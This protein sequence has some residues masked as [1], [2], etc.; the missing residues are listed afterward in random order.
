MNRWLVLAAFAIA[1]RGATVE[2]TFLGPVNGPPPRAA[3]DGQGNVLLVTSQAC[4]ILQECFPFTV[5]KLDANGRVL[6]RKGIGDST[7]RWQLGAVAL[8]RAGNILLSGT[9]LSGETNLPLVRALRSRPDGP[10][11][12]YLMQLSPDGNRILFASYL[13]G[14]GSDELRSLAVDAAGNAVATVVTTSSDFPFTGR[15]GPPLNAPAIPQAAIVR[16][17]LTEP[18]VRLAY[19]IAFSLAAPPGD[20]SVAG[21]GTVVVSRIDSSVAT[22]FQAPPTDLIEIRPDGT[23]RRIP[24]PLPGAAQTRRAIPAADGGFWITGTTAGGVLPTTPNAFQT[25]PKSLTYLRWEGPQSISPPG[26]IR[27]LSTRQLAVCRADANRIYAATTTGLART[28]DNGWTWELVN[29]SAPLRNAPAIATSAGNLAGFGG[30]RLWVLAAAINPP[31]ILF[32]DDRG[33]T[34]RTLP[35]PAGLNGR[36]SAIAALPDDPRV[37]H[38]ASQNSLFTTRDLGETWTEFRFPSQVAS[39]AADSASVAVGTFVPSRN[40]MLSSRLHWSDDGGETFPRSISATPFLP[41]FDPYEPGTLYFVSGASLYRTTRETFPEFEE[42]PRAPVP[43]SLFDF[44]PDL[45]G[46]LLAV[47]VD[48]RG[49]RSA[50][51]GRSWQAL[52]TTALRA[53]S[54]VQFVVGAGGVAH[55]VQPSPIEGFV[56]KL[57]P[58]GEL[59]YLTYLGV[60]LTSDPALTQT[61]TGQIVVTGQMNGAENFPGQVLRNNTRL[62]PDLPTSVDIFAI[63]FEPDTRPS[64]AAAL[65]GIGFDQLWWS[66]AGPGNTLL[67]LGNSNSEDFPGVPVNNNPGLFLARLR[68]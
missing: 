27:S 63:A 56:G 61:A 64:Y 66:G 13:G 43:L 6:L 51:G 38:V 65:V 16:L 11:D 22:P 2:T 20:L 12:A 15:E 55:L 18:T 1:L 24:V 48:A 5:V 52:P 28:E 62:P 42:L 9:V 10:A 58:A 40:G 29:E 68:P 14:N 57:T 3:G 50:D 36:P 25:L 19:A 8:D 47:A 7:W 54:T 46:V 34:F 49:Y 45:P 32:S 41:R 17:T 35:L 59:S 53:Q 4:S 26:P 37:L 60:A 30:S 39:V 23:R 21:D 33:A 31:A 67:L 44:Q